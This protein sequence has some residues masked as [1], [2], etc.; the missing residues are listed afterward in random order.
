MIIDERH[1][2]NGPPLRLND[3]VAFLRSSGRTEKCPFCSYDGDWD[4]HV[5]LTDGE[6]AP[7]PPLSVFMADSK[8]EPDAPHRCAA[9]TCPQCGHFS[10]ISEYRIRLHL[11][12]KGSVNG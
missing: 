3:L 1:L 9:M 10:M 5:E 12:C 6:Y 4:I 7:N 8:N 11:A 2:L